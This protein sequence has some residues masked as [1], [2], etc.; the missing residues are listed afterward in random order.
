MLKKYVGML[1]ADNN[2]LR[3]V[4]TLGFL[5]TIVQA[6]PSYCLLQPDKSF[7]IAFDKRLKHNKH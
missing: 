2:K 7:L 1:L 5:R 6:Q 3:R 4:K